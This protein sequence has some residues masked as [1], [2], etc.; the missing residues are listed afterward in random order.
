MADNDSNTLAES[1]RYANVLSALQDQLH[2]VRH[3]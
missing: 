3:A 2:G 1:G